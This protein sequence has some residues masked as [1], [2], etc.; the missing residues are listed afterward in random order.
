[1]AT[2]I[3]GVQDYIPQIQPFIPD[4]NFYSGA[5]SFK[6]GKHDA[7][8]RQLSNIY[9]SLLNA[10][11]TREDN[12]QSRDRFFK[13]IEQDI[14]K[15]AT[16][17]LSL[18][19][20][21]EAATGVFN[22]MLDNK[23]I[24]KDMVWTKNWQKQY[25][26]GQYLKNCVDPE[27][28]GG[29]WWEGGDRLMQYKRAAFANAAPVDA[30]RMQNANYVAYQD[31]TKKAMNLAKEAGLSVSVDQITGQW[32]T[33]TKNGPQLIQPLQNLLMG[34]IGKDPKIAEYYKAS[35]ELNRL[36][37]MHGN[38][39]QYGSLEAAEQAYIAQTIPTAEQ[40]FS[41]AE[42]VLEDQLS[43]TQ[44]KGDKMDKVIATSTPDKRTRLQ[45][46]RDEFTMIE[47]GYTGTLDQVKNANGYIGVA[48]RNQRYT[49][50]QIDNILA[51]YQLG[52]DI[53]N[54]AHTLAYKDFEF[55]IKKNPYAVESMRH[56]NRMMLE[57]FRTRNKMML[58]KYKFGLKQHKE[59]MIAT[60]GAE[61]NTPVAVVDIVGN[62]SVGNLD[63]DSYENQQRGFKAFETD[64]E[65]IRT[66]LSA[67]EKSIMKQVM[68]RTSR[69]ADNG[70]VQAKEDYI[71]MFSNFVAAAND[72]PELIARPSAS[73]EG[74]G[75]E[76]SGKSKQIG[77]S[78]EVL[79]GMNDL[80]KQINSAQT[81]DGKYHLAKKFKMNWNWL[82]G[83]Q[84]D[85]FYENTISDV[86]KP[87]DHNGAMRNY[88]APILP[89]IQSSQQRIN[90]K[91]L[92]LDQ[93][94]QWYAEESK[95]VITEA[96]GKEKYGQEWADA[97]EA[98][99][100]DQGHTVD[101]ATFVSNMKL[102][103]YSEQQAKGLYRA[104]VEDPSG[105]NFGRLVWNVATGDYTEAI[106]IDAQAKAAE[107][108]GIHD[109]WK[110]AFSEFARPEGD[111]AWYQITGAGDYTAMGQR[112]T[113]VDPAQY[114]SIATMGT[115]GFLKDALANKDAVFSSGNFTT[116]LPENS[117]AVK[118][119]AATLYNDMI[120]MKKGSNRP[121]LTVTY[122]DIAAS[123]G[124]KVGLNIQVNEGY[125]KK[126][127]GSKNQPGV[128]GSLGAEGFTVYLDKNATQNL[129]TE[130]TKET[131]LEKTMKWSGQVTMDMYPD[132]AK[133]FKIE[134]DPDNGNYKAS[135]M[136]MTGLDEQGYPIWDYF[137]NYHSFG[138]DV[139]DLVA[140]YHNLIG[141]VVNQ[142]KAIENKWLLENSAR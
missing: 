2:Y 78:P 20:N 63:P 30:M 23:A 99:I 12:V 36:D 43:V 25:Q 73:D 45:R 104:D 60:G 48:Q 67:N 109:M 138:T 120:L 94:D 118:T 141:N 134:S 100:D 140:Q 126:Y 131:H 89:T 80:A 71:N 31:V 19:Q 86:I 137:E 103:G 29:S 6:Q 117:D 56:K 136:M 8:R 102:K 122:S 59:Q 55:Q 14:K 95:N 40:A 34:S 123:D 4:Y 54:A 58:E 53:S 37:F 83:S 72:N 135:G 112:Y 1:M 90:A 35:A 97:F 79:A 130:G 32:I 26:K 133:D 121:F 70:D 28:C 114:R 127:Q 124:N 57:E 62:T 105:W 96:A 76:M 81:L 21:A 50:E 11:L 84:V 3:P 87:T 22:Q 98:Y 101:K 5:L 68:D 107:T 47:N 42:G 13:T 108:P 44:Q 41:R 125:R 142:N 111:R 49:G 9:G 52:S 92:A 132:Y 61:A 10:P 128:M 115:M 93:M 64:R 39:S 139:N 75:S 74:G 106:K 33:T 69:A 27:K 82:A 16:M 110:R 17:D 116:N 24:V 88:L 113:A 85:S 7:A 65:G 46:I 91:N 38:Q 18:A 129:F 77:A 51:S 66:D 119:M 15:M